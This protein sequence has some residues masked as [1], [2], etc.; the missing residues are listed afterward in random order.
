MEIA[1]PTCHARYRVADEA[2]PPEGREISCAQC[3]GRWQQV[4]GPLPD[5]MPDPAPLG[6]GIPDV[7]AIDMPGMAALGPAAEVGPRFGH[8]PARRG[9]GIGTIGWL[10]ILVLLGVAAAV[11]YGVYAGQLSLS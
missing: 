3:G 4:R 2:I 7:G 1:C 10:L 6:M 11:A 5:A 9:P 8:Q